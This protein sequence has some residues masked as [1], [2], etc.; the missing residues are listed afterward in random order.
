M[1]KGVT[2]LGIIGACGLLAYLIY[3]AFI[4]TGGTAVFDLSGPVETTTIV[5]EQP[6]PFSRYGAGSKS[7]LAVLV[8][9]PDSSWLGLA[10]GLKAIGV[11]FLVTDDIRRALEHTVVVVYPILSGGVVS[12][13]ALRAVL[14]H[15]LNGGVLIAHNAIGAGM[16]DVFGFDDSVPGRARTSVAFAERQPGGLVLSDLRERLIRLGDPG[17]E[18]EALGTY[19]YTNPREIPL[20]E[21]DDGTAAVTRRSFGK[22]AAYAVGVD[23]GDFLLRGHNG[24]TDGLVESYVNAYTPAGDVWLRWLRAVYEASEPEAVTLGTVP[25]GR[26]FSLL[27]THDV[28]A[29]PSV[30]NTPAFV[31]FEQARGVRATYFVQAKYVKDW[32]DR[33]LITP[34]TVGFLS[35]LTEAGMELASHTVCHSHVFDVFPVGTGTERYPEYRPFVA[36]REKAEGGTILGELRVSK[37]LL[38]HFGG[39]P[40]VSFRPGNLRNP[41]ALP[42]S[43]RATGYRFSS[44]MTC[45]ESLTHLPFQLNEN[46]SAKAEVPV[47]EFPISL[48]D[49]MPISLEELLAR[50]E[51]LMEGLARY[52]GTCVVLIHPNVLEPKLEYERQLLEAAGPRAWTGTLRGFGE[53]WAARNAVSIDTASDARGKTVYLDLPAE[54][55]DLSVRVPSSWEL[56]GC[57]PAWGATALEPGRVLLKKAAGRVRLYFRPSV[58]AL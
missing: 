52:G 29:R 43:L 23:I 17:G 10:H 48:E 9:V 6:T 25:G 8:T 21:Y 4:R 35:E 54:I 47:F 51:E 39:H 31:R 42:Q 1:K 56:T 46:R 33:P 16:R 19:G 45:G 34:E 27:L 41:R 55:E 22:G 32:N 12:P 3:Y 7:R 24:R 11:P 53:W 14:G 20:A 30:K 5:P 49:T 50:S 2:L 18:A 40:V 13:E 57:D 44:T 37:F 38:E 26:A 28:D 15:P 36:D 58:P